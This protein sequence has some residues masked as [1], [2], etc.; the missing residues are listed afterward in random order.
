MS[1]FTEFAQQEEEKAVS[2]PLEVDQSAPLSKAKGNV[3]E[4]PSARQREQNNQ[5]EGTRDR[6]WD[7]LGADHASIGT[8]F[9]SRIQMSISTS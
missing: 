6:E 9:H 3:D 4:N 8:E 7:Y 1:L 5:R 2:A